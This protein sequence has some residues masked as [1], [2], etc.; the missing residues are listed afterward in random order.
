MNR[1]GFSLI[2]LMITLII[3]SVLVIIVIP[4]LKQMKM[5]ANET[6]AVTYM[7]SWLA[8]QEMYK[9]K[10]PQNR[11]AS[12][13]EAL[14]R[15]GCLSAPDPGGT[16]PKICG[17]SFQIR[18]GAEMGDQ[19]KIWWEGWAQPLVKDVTGRFSFYINSRDGLIRYSDSGRAN[20][21]SPPLQSR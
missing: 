2:E 1:R 14:I 7:R 5:V 13:D 16:D 12:S 8:A 10:D 20:E 18:G 4:Q 17:Y 9:R 19:G 15:S 6:W 21:N 3:M 11:Y